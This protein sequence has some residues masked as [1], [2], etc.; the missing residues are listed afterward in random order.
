M[1]LSDSDSDSGVKRAKRKKSRR[2]RLAAE[3]AFEKDLGL[4]PKGGLVDYHRLV[5]ALTLLGLLY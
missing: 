3:R 1:A 2:E 4:R 5:G